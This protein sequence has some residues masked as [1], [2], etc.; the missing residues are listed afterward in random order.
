ME[1]FIDVEKL[2]ASK[3]PKLLKRL[4]RFVI[5]YVKRI[6]HQEEVNRILHE[7]KELMNADFCNEIV[8]RFKLDLHTFG[9]ENIPKSGGITIACNHPLGGMDAIALVDQIAD[10]R[11]DIKF[12]VND[13]LLNLENLKG[14]FAGVNKHGATA[15]SSLQQVDELFRSDMAVVVFPAGLVSRKIDGK[16]QDLEWKKTFVSRARKYDRPIIP[17]NID[18]RLSNFFYR[19]HKFRSALGIKANVE[20][21]YLV[22]ELFKQVGETIDIT[23][24]KAI[25]PEELKDD[26]S[27]REWAAII[28]SKCYALKGMR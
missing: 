9:L 26:K 11:P 20:M 22:N 28:R 1:K 6:L 27:D 8:D 10:H 25:L 18:G 15:L 13:L 5:R 2:I 19:L 24:G 4:P 12:I 21:F 16:V 3:N 23:V 17:I 14:L 7:N